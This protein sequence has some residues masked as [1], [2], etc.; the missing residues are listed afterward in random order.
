MKK[1]ICAKK[2]PGETDDNKMSLVVGFIIILFVCL[3]VAALQ[4]PVFAGIAATG[5]IICCVRIS[6]LTRKGHSLRCAIRKTLIKIASIGTFVS[7]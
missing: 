6:Y 2:E 3:V 1:C 7:P 5:F 4:P